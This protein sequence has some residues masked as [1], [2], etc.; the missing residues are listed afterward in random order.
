MNAGMDVTIK[1]VDV[2]PVQFQAQIQGGYGRSLRNGDP[3]RPYY[4]MSEDLELDGMRVCVAHGLHE[5]A[6]LRDR[7]SDATANGRSSGHRAGI[8]PRHTTFA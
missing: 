4:F 8:R 5:R 3:R 7:P 2:A 1:E 6:R